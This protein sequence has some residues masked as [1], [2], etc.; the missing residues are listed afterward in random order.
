MQGELIVN[1][2]CCGCS[3][4]YSQNA[5]T[6]D[7]HVHGSDLAC[8]DSDFR[9]QRYISTNELRVRA[10]LGQHCVGSGLISSDNG[11]VRCG[12]MSRD[13]QSYR[14]TDSRCSADYDDIRWRT[15]PR[16]EMRFG[17]TCG[18]YSRRHLPF[19]FLSA[20]EMRIWECLR[21]W[22]H[23]SDKRNLIFAIGLFGVFRYEFTST[24]R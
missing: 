17:G 16:K 6:Q 1:I 22:Q 20:R 4:R 10:K 24:Q 15:Q 13:G 5:L 12:T 23:P 3:T 19:V 8:R 2:L 18:T 7:Q 11:D 14:L 9:H 21:W